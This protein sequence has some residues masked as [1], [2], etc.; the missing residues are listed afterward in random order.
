MTG[1]SHSDE[2]TFL[3]AH[4][5][6]FCIMQVEVFCLD[7]DD[8]VL[9]YLQWTAGTVQMECQ[10]STTDTPSRQKSSLWTSWSPSKSMHL[11]LLSES[12]TSNSLL[13]LVMRTRDKKWQR[14][15]DVTQKNVTWLHLYVCEA[16]LYLNTG[17]RLRHC[18]NFSTTSLFLLQLSHHPVHRG[19]L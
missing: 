7:D 14:W 19:P 18:C 2:C 9:F 5:F 1:L 13:L 10:S 11:S 3:H 15:K 8:D 6:F 12:L 16:V 17:Q 4:S